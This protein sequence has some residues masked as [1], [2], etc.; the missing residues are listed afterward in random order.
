MPICTIVD[1][2]LTY[3][4]NTFIND[5]SMDPLK[6]E[7]TVTCSV[8]GTG[9]CKSSEFLHIFTKELNYFL[10]SSNDYRKYAYIPISDYFSFFYTVTINSTIIST[11]TTNSFFNLLIASVVALTQDIYR[12]KTANVVVNKQDGSLFFKF[13]LSKNYQ[14]NSITVDLQGN[15][16]SF[17]YPMRSAFIY[18]IV[19][20]V[21]YRNLPYTDKSRYSEGFFSKYKPNIKIINYKI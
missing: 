14:D 4:I 20:A 2:N 19:Q 11:V 15:S 12:Y 16:S 1:N 5:I 13:I 18:S 17:T 10:N 21:E 8:S 9:A 7:R 3:S 6:K